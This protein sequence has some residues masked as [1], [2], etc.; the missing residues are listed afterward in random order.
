MFPYLELLDHEHGHWC[1]RCHRASG[2]RHIV[3]ITTGA[4]MVMGIGVGCVICGSTDITVNLD[5]AY[6]CS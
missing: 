5:A 6:R 3:T 4:V 2:I 1:N